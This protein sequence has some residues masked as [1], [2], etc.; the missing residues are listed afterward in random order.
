MKPAIV[1]PWLGKLSETFIYNHVMGLIDLDPMVVCL[2]REN[3]DIFPADG[4]DV[5][6]LP[7]SPPPLLQRLWERI[8][9]KIRGEWWSWYARDAKLA[10]EWAVE[11]GATV[12]LA[13]YGSTG[14]AIANAVRDAGIPL[15]V[16][17][18]GHD[19]SRALRH[20]G[21]V[22]GLRQLYKQAAALIVVADKMKAN[23]AGA[24]A[25]ESIIHKI[26][27]GV[28]TLAIRVPERKG[29]DHVTFLHVGRLW[30][31]KGIFETLRAFAAVAEGNSNVGL[32]VIG[33][34][35]LRA[36]A[37]AM[38]M[39]LGIAG[40]V[41]FLGALPH[42]RVMEEMS[43]ADVFVLHSVTAPDG[44]EEGLPVSIL[45]AAAHG[46]PI[47][48]TRH[49]GIVEEVVEG[50]TG[51]LVDEHDV[52]AYADAMAALAED[53]AL[54]KSM[55][56]AGRNLV[57]ESFDRRRQLAGLGSLLREIAGGAC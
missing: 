19:A 37:E 55:G 46:L 4:V 48:S 12:A 16:H 53:A 32:R 34:G 33:E 30:E 38:A 50:Q 47:V 25:P 56:T 24:G 11:R 18:H 8:P 6:V 1:T 29:R 28:D 26:P 35:G 43:A 10:A 52:E 14:L 31:K 21:Y 42:A 3:E 57:E 13:E 36:S 5:R 15:V 23:L 39:E 20:A 22:R 41:C 45:E 17:F 49:A 54:R 7:A 51:Y 2:H 40:S 9:A 27:Y 44:D